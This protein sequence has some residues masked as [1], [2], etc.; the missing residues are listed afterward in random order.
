MQISRD[1]LSELK[2]QLGGK[3]FAMDFETFGTNWMAPGFWVRCVSFHN[4]EVSISVDLASTE[5]VYY[6]YAYELFEFLADQPG[7]IAHNAGYEI[8]CVYG[9]VGK[10]P[11]PHACTYALYMLLACE[12]SPGQS[13]ALKQAG[14]ELI[15]WEAWDKDLGNKANLALLP[16]EKLG[17]YNQLDSAATWE[18]YK[19]CCRA[20]DEGKEAGEAWAQIFWDYYK[21]DFTN[22]LMLQDEAYREGLYIDPEYVAGYL[23]QVEQEVEDTR[24]AF[25]DHPD[26]RP[27]IEAYD[28]AVVE[29]AERALQNYSKKYRADGTETVNY[30][31]A[32][33]KAADL[34]GVSHFLLSSPQQ[35]RWLFYDRL[36][37]DVRI[38]TES[39][40]PS[41]D[42]DAL[43][44]IPVYGKLLLNHRDAISQLKFLQALLD[45]EENGVVRI[46]IK[47]PGTVTA[48]CSAGTLEGA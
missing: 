40:Q 37:C 9:M 27:H 31:K 1:L 25:L 10:T 41:T 18:L 23:Q 4:D 21:E 13:A 8:G 48:R 45:N 7:I 16:F 39:G 47:C 35:L 14:P 30:Q 43:A 32:Q 38:Y 36:K 15:G 46:P 26:I 19:I 6:P 29:E 22:A 42:A 44:T 12:G 33:K 17:W 28:R 24:R 3:L 34:K 20:I 5:G 11:T 2:T